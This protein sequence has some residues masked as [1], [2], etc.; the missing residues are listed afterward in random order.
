MSGKIPAQI[1][2][3]LF[4]HMEAWKSARKKPWNLYLI[5]NNAP[6]SSRQWIVDQGTGTS[7]NRKLS[8]SLHGGVS[9][10]DWGLAVAL[11][12]AWAFPSCVIRV[13]TPCSPAQSRA[14]GDQM[15]GREHRERSCIPGKGLICQTENTWI[16]DSF[17]WA[18]QNS[19][20]PVI[21]CWWWLW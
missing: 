7:H 13:I 10:T 1:S 12:V 14:Q 11:C 16:C 20:M 8:G 2:M 3:F 15:L 18:T 17:K 21:M 9:V 6:Q 19:S 4:M 5:F